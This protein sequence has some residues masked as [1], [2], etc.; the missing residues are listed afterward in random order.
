MPLAHALAVSLI[1]MLTACQQYEVSV[2]DRVLYT[3]RDLMADTNIADPA[4]R[5]CLAQ[6]LDDARVAAPGEL[7][8]LNCSHA[9]IERLDGIA[10]FTG[11]EWLNLDGNRI[12]NLVELGQ[13]ERLTR[14]QLAD[15][16]VVDPVPMTTTAGL[17]YLD[18]SGNTALQCPQPGAFPLATQV[19]LP[20]HCP[21]RDQ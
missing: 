18:L 4:L 9:G 2:N 5:D 3:P 7:R 10:V 21:D 20:E 1:A 11:L 8:Q 16:Q 15:N 6:A 13:L 17:A 14:V 12:R 19:I